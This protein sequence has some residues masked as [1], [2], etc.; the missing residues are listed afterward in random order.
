[1]APILNVS[2]EGVR[3]ILHAVGTKFVPLLTYPVQRYPT[4][5]YPGPNGS[6]SIDLADRLDA[7]I[8]NYYAA[9]ESRNDKEIKAKIARLEAV[10]KSGAKLRDLLRGDDNRGSKEENDRLISEIEILLNRSVSEIDDWK[11]RLE[12]PLLMG[13]AQ[14]TG[15]KRR[16]R[17]RSPFE[18]LAG[19]YLPD[20]FW[21]FYGKKPTLQRGPDGKIIRG[22]F[23]RFV[24]QVLV[25]FDIT[26]SGAPFSSEAIARALTDARTARFRA[27]PDG[28]EPT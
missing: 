20:D 25:E 7:S 1:M 17:M 23:I 19:T 16:F 26:N 12:D 28:V 10:L 14:W 27:K 21:D 15:L 6:R 4:H 3:R 8:N 13:A 24:Q 22:P 2:P 11:E 18:W 9:I 5:R